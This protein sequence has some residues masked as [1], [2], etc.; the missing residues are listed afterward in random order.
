MEDESVEFLSEEKP[1]QPQDPVLV[2]TDAEG[3]FKLSVLEGSIG[4]LRGY[5]YS[6]SRESAKCPQREKL[7]KAYK[8]I[9]TNRIKS[10]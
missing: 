6:F 2:K 10:N 8:D 9:E 4:T 5:L 7:A 3:R 1:D